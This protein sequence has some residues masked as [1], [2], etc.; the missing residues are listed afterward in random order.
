MREPSNALACVCVCDIVTLAK[1]NRISL[2]VVTAAE[3][4]LDHWM[5]LVLMINLERI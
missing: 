3:L 5:M 1:G 4:T 2:A